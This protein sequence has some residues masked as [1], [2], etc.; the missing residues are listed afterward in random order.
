MTNLSLWPSL[1]LDQENCV[2]HYTGSLDQSTVGVK[3]IAIMMEDFDALGNVRSSIPV[4]F[5]AQV[6]TP[7]LDRH[8]GYPEWFADDHQ[9][10]DDHADDHHHDENSA[11]EEHQSVSR[12]R[13]SAPTYCTAKSR[14]LKG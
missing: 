13:R 10:E 11:D 8:V 9:H 12:G 2:V 6:W 7:S 14:V 5:L 3:P 4:Q 1:S